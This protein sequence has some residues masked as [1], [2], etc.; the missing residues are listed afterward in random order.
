VK[1]ASR[2][3]VVAAATLLCACGGG[4][5][6]APS[7]ATSH[8]ITGV[9][10]YDQDADG[11][12]GADERVRLPGVRVVAGGQAATTDA[13]GEFTITGVPGPAQSLSLPAEGL[14]PY[15]EAGRLPRIELPL[16][17]GTVVATPVVLPTGRNH[18]NTYVGF[19][20]SITWG[21]GA[22]LR[23]GWPLLLEA[24]LRAAWGEATVAV[25]GVPSSLSEDGV[26]RL[27]DA[28]A[29]RRPAYTLILYGTNDWSRCAFRAPEE[30]FTV[31]RLREMIRMARAAGSLPVVGTIPPVDPT[32]SAPRVA[33]RNYW[34]RIQNEL[35]R[36]MVAQEGAVLAD[37]WTAFGPE[38]QWPDL[39]FDFLHPNDGGHERIA[40]AFAQAITRPRGTR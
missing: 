3:A 18:P 25:D 27:P 13:R 2:Q 28:L 34:V 5:P 29:E 20:D 40:G 33:D 24:Q 35:I 9:V 11:V 36:P 14:P 10:F 31:E 4:S 17:A 37:A 8:S 15:F 7:T 38:S 30:C 1:A 32:A 16:A 26:R 22:T 6:S 12:L 23:R 21:Q 39:F 19:G